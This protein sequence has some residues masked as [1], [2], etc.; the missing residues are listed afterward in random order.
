MPDAPTIAETLPGVEFMSWLG[1]AM[2]PATPR[3]VVERIN[4]EIRDA[5][6]LPDVQQRLSEGGNVASP[7]SPGE[8]RQKVESEIARWT[9]VIEAGGIKV[10]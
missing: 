5:L 10:D 7:S 8:M 4:K 1:L 6:E 9:R 3:P 2:A